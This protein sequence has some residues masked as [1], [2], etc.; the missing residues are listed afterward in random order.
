MLCYWIF[1]FKV[2]LKVQ[3]RDAEAFKELGHL[4][5]RE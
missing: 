1:Q 5:R 4:E 2:K 3:K